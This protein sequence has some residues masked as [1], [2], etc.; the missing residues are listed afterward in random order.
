MKKKFT[1]SLKEKFAYGMGDFALMIGYGAIG[2]YLVFFLTDV[3]GLPAAWAGYIFLIA[4]VWDAFIDY[5][6][7]FI[8]DATKSRFGRRRPYILFGAI[9]LGI[10]F[11]LIWI[12]PFQSPAL[13]FVYYVSI[14]VLFNTAFTIVSIPYNSMMPELTQDYDERTSISGF[15]MGLSFSGTLVA[16]AGIMIIVD[17]IFPGKEAY[18]SSF[19]I[20]GAVFGTIMVASLL[21]TFFGTRERVQESAY[22]I[23]EGFFKTFRSILKLKEFRIILGMFLFNMVGFD[24]IQVMLIY[25]LKHVI[26]VT[27]DVTFIVMAVPLVVAIIAAPLWIWLG[28]KWGKKK[29][30]MVAAVYLTFS[31]MLC[32][33]APV[34]NLTFML[35]ISA[36]AGIGISASQVIPLSIIPDVIGVDEYKNGTRREGA[37]YGITT[38]L[39]KVA[40]AL[41]VN[42]ATLLLGFWGYIESTADKVI[43]KV[44]QPDSA[45]SAIRIMMGIGPGIFF[46]ISAVFVKF[47]PINK[48][49]FNEIKQI[50][51]DRKKQITD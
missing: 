47:L 25:F 42:V 29:A 48:E 13:L 19:P 43:D 5:A 28:E 20:M 23:K 46:L 14:S 27:E 30:Y 51:E 1:L 2:F 12:V 8:T 34:G 21:F 41:A 17:L 40:S 38:F 44:I 10:I 45:I 6:M 50:I 9:P 36:F 31:L 49:R 33:V 16:A 39:Y 37:F 3:A 32:L 4:R 35:I 15:R 26:R 11:A 22:S 24:L 18:R 7:G